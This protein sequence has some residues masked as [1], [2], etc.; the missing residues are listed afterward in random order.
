[1]LVWKVLTKDL[2]VLDRSYPTWNSRR[3]LAWAI[4]WTTHPPWWTKISVASRVRRKK[5]IAQSVRTVY[6]AMGVSSTQEMASTACKLSTI[7]IVQQVAIKTQI[8]RATKAEKTFWLMLLR[9]HSNSNLQLRW[10][11]WL[12]SS[13][14]KHITRAKLLK[15]MK[16]LTNLCS[17][18]HINLTLTLNP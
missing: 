10:T 13:T 8:T 18:I 14:Q 12:Y 9:Q 15:I 4:W 16:M 5:S 7:K 11:M 3:K 17:S 2:G 1:M 6:V